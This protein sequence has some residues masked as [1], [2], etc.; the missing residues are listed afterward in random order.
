MNLKKAKK[1]LTS[2]I[3]INLLTSKQLSDPKKRY[4]QMEIIE[5]WYPTI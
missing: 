4:I 5:T 3:I 1:R 2:S